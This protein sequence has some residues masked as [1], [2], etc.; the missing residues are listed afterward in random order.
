MTAISGSNSSVE[1]AFSVLSLLLS[2]RRLSMN[3]D[4]MENL[5]MVKCNDRAWSTKEKSD[6]LNRAV[7]MYLEKRRK[8]KLDA[9]MSTEINEVNSNE[10]I[11]SDESDSSL[12]SDSSDYSTE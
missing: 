1:R 4:L 10:V 2:D 5:L 8:R 12:D 6:I 3:H 7:Q 11:S 9:R